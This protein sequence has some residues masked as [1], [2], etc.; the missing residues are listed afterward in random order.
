MLKKVLLAFVIAVM[1]LLAL[2]AMQPAGYAV[3]RSTTIAAPPATVFGLVND[4]HKWEGWSPWA[5]IDPGMKQTYEGAASGTGAVYKWSGNDKAGEGMMLITESRP[6]DHVGIDLS[7]TRPYVSSSVIG[8]SIKPE[9]NG[10]KVTWNMTGRNNFALKAISLFSSMDKMVGPDF[11]R[12]L[13]QLK[14]LAESA[15]SK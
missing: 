12:G 2:I 6:D 3:T 9:G 7:F 5:A 11:E 14:T 13:A 15:G 8:L 10:S 4:F 1:V